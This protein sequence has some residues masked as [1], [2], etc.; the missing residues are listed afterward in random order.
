MLKNL[1]EDSTIEPTAYWSNSSSNSIIHKLIVE[2]SVEIK[3][4]LESLING[5][6][7]M[8]SILFIN[9]KEK[10]K[11]MRIIMNIMILIKMVVLI[12]KILKK[13]LNIMVQFMKMMYGILPLQRN[14]T[15]PILQIFQ[16]TI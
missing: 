3:N 5:E 15:I 2:S 8:T 13:L 11:A 6:T 16:N 14:I 12:M 4:D 9:K 7:L 10:L 1:I